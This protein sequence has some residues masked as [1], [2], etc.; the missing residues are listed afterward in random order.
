[1]DNSKMA[2]KKPEKTY[3][4]PP[5]LYDDRNKGPLHRA[6]TTRNYYEPKP[7]KKDLRAHDATKEDWT[8]YA[9]QAARKAETLNANAKPGEY[10]L[11][12][13][14]TN[15]ASLKS[16][17]RGTK[18]H[19]GAISELEKALASVT[20]K[21]TSLVKYEGL[22]KYERVERIA[23]A[24]YKTLD[25]AVSTSIAAQQIHPEIET[26]SG[27]PL[28]GAKKHGP[29]R[30]A[31]GYYERHGREYHQL[32][33][34]VIGITI[35]LLLGTSFLTGQISGAAVIAELENS[36]DFP[37]TLLIFLVVV[38]LFGM[39]WRSSKHTNFDM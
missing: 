3:L 13:Y 31:H 24:I 22:P 30:G 28:Y 38:F 25:E 39:M 36:S 29:G 20:H 27:Q 21:P 33:V 2:D 1:M 17:I 23:R 32:A 15:E 4:S 19:K 26:P 14:F 8:F 12:K 35:L 10:K 6:H 9:R 7:P 34:A 5:I 37:Y 18:K 16:V 11:P